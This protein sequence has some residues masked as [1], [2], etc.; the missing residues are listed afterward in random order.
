MR[1]NLEIQTTTTQ[2]RL[3]CALKN[4]RLLPDGC[5]CL[6]NKGNEILLRINIPPQFTT[7]AGLDGAGQWLGLPDHWKFTLMDV[8]LWGHI[9]TLNYT[10]P[11]D[12]EEDFT[13]RIFE[14]AATIRQQ[15]GIF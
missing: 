6:N 3:T 15:P 1:P 7:I 9:K 12:S 2:Q 8:F 14:S 10:S 13:V 11:V 4:A 5:C